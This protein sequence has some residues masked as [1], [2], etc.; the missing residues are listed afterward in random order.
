MVYGVLAEAFASE[1]TARMTA[2]DNATDNAEDMLAK[3]TLKSNQARQARITNELSEIV[4]GAEVLAAQ[5]MSSRFGKE[6]E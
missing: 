6:S 2:M 3:L 4:G 5:T 1:Q